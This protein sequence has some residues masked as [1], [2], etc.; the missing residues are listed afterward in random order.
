MF[1]EL[2]KSLTKEEIDELVTLGIARSTV[3]AWRTG[4]RLPTRPQTVHL[5][6]VKHVDVIKL[7]AEL[8]LMEAAP[9]QR[10]L[11]RRILSEAGAA[12]AVWLLAFGLIYAPKDANATPLKLGIDNQALYIM[13]T[14]KAIQKVAAVLGKLVRGLSNW[15]L[16][17][18]PIHAESTTKEYAVLSSI[19]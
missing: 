14:R 13:S 1:T 5:A 15:A 9:E 8:M 4:K 18:F 6:Q 11:F 3:S 7:E 19:A 12:V 2:V 17:R 16:R 10:D